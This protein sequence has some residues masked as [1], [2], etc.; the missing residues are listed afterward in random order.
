M[1]NTDLD[2]PPN[3]TPFL[4][5][6]TQNKPPFPLKKVGRIPVA[7]PPIRQAYPTYDRWAVVIEVSAWILAISAS[8]ILGLLSFSGMLAIWPVLPF[9]FA[10]FFFAVVIEG[11]IYLDSI[12][13]ALGKL[14]DPHAYENQL[15][16]LYL[17]EK[18]ADYDKNRDLYLLNAPNKN[19]LRRVREHNQV[20]IFKQDAV[21]QIGF[22]NAEGEYEQRPLTAEQSEFL[23]HYPQEQF[24]EIPGHHEFIDDLLQSFDSNLPR[25]DRDHYPVL[26]QQY[27]AQA[28]YL[29]K[30]N[31]Y[32]HTQ[33]ANEE[34]QAELSNMNLHLNKLADDMRAFLFHDMTTQQI[35]AEQ[36]F[37]ITFTNKRYQLNL[38]DMTVTV[39]APVE[40]KSKTKKTQAMTPFQ[41]V[42]LSTTKKL[43]TPPLLDLKVLQ[44]NDSLLNELSEKTYEFHRHK[45]KEWIAGD[46]DAWKKH[47]A[48]HSLNSRMGFLVA[49]FSGLIM[50]IGTTYLIM[51][52]VSVTWLALIPLSLF[53]P[54][55]A[56]LALLAGVAYGLL[57]YNSLTD[58]FLDNPIRKFVERV[59]ALSTQEMTFKRGLILGLSLA[60]FVVTLFLTICTAGTWLTVFHK[61]KPLFTWLAVIPNVLLNIVIPILIGI[62][63]LP[64][65]LQ[66]V[67]NTLDGLEVNPNLDTAINSLD[68]RNWRLPNGRLPSSWAEASE[69][70]SARIWEQWVPKF[71][72]ITKEEFE[73]ETDMQRRN[74]YRIIYRMF[75]EPLRDFIFVGHLASAGATSDQ[76]EG[77]PV[78]VSFVLNFLFE[79]AEDWDWIWGRPHVDDF[80]TVDLLKERAQNSD[81]HNH[82]KNIPILLLKTLFEPILQ[83]AAK[84]DNDYRNIERGDEDNVQKRYAKLQGLK[85]DVPAPMIPEYRKGSNFNLFLFKSAVFES[86]ANL[87][88]DDGCTPMARV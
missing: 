40:A 5:D 39:D 76:I 7:A 82:D 53:P 45:L 70:M 11:Q 1:Q 81:D 42:A 73:L 6:P 13:S 71:L 32:L 57:I 56:P 24:M 37:H 17:Q 2:P 86:S 58:I 29:R 16:Q 38:N 8:L 28:R 21:F 60:L 30:L 35:E 65:S 48:K 43:S 12:R 33:V 52:A 51:E 23:S 34:K 27:I 18:L 10:A 4:K 68:P 59:R 47:L 74:P 54:V 31:C 19:D 80:D 50:G 77:V 44:D 26:I 87:R 78:W 85:P 69:W 62:S 9:A 3:S 83:R 67:A 64:F 41:G 88:C 36:S 75:F 46:Q 49:A 22:R 55:I 72:G 15:T 20:I 14:F 66:S 63:V 61:T 84:W 79:W 25:R